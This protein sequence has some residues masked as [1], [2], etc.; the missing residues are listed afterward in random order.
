MEAT[1]FAADMLVITAKCPSPKWIYDYAVRACSSMVIQYPERYFGVGSQPS[2]P[3][4]D[5]P[6]SSNRKCPYRHPHIIHFPTLLGMYVFS[7]QSFTW[8]LPLSCMSTHNFS[9]FFLL[10]FHLLPTQVAILI[11]KLTLYL[12]LTCL[13]FAHNL[14]F[15]P[16]TNIHFH[17]HSI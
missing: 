10:S 1:S 2:F 7:L 13:T 17:S 9:L 6:H 8:Y 5:Y 4:V 14:P 11:T 16:P 15:L 3:Q 12:H